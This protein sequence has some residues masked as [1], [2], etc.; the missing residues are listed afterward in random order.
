MKIDMRSVSEFL[1]ASLLLVLLAACKS[2]QY[3]S[4]A[5]SP[6]SAVALSEPL[7]KTMAFEE[8]KTMWRVE[9]EGHIFMFTPYPE[10]ALPAEPVNMDLSLLRNESGEEIPVVGAVVLV[11]V[12]ILADQ[13]HRDFL[14]SSSKYEEA[15]PGL[16]RTVMTFTS[17]GDREVDFK[18]Y[19]GGRTITAHFPYKVM[20]PMYSPRPVPLG[21]IPVSQI[22]VALN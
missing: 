22:K 20:S 13:E 1:G 7:K 6:G 21:K 15:A 8:M 17:S 3:R 16:Y 12:H 5:E 9:K 14:E 11:N 18:V 4:A 19:T 2:A 10:A